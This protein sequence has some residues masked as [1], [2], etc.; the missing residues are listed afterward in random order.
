[1]TSAG[2][3]IRYKSK[4][5]IILSMQTTFT[6][7]IL[8]TDEEDYPGPRPIRFEGTVAN[9]NIKHSTLPVRSWKP[10][11]RTSLNPRPAEPIRWTTDAQLRSISKQ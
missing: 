9:E 1:M 6:C 3:P 11:R 4:L 10:R 8:N 7:P 5:T 2:A